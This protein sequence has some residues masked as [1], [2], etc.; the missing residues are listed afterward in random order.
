MKFNHWLALGLFL[1]GITL[2]LDIYPQ[3]SGSIVEMTTPG[4]QVNAGDILVKID[5]RQ[6]QLKLQHLEITSSIKQ[7]AFED[8]L[9][10]LN[11]TQELYDRMVASHRDLDIAKIEHNAKK[12]E[13]DAHNVLIKIQTIE[14]EKYQIKSPI[15]GTVK[16]TPQLRNVTNIA[17]P[18]V[19]VV[20]E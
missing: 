16:E 18:K 9:L 17:S 11:Q 20:I 2:A 19:L 12:R 6:A 15:S 14:L 7:Q 8:A 4:K 10:T 1:P 13:H 3:V 5:D